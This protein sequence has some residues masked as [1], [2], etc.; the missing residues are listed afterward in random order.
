MPNGRGPTMYIVTPPELPR[1]LRLADEI[2]ALGWEVEIADTPERGAEAG[3]RGVCIIMLTRDGW[4]DPALVE[5]I[6]QRPTILVPVLAEPMPLPNG[7]WTSDPI[8]M[9]YSLQEVAAMVINAIDM[10]TSRSSATR[11]P[12]RPRDGM[13]ESRSPSRLRDDDGLQR[14]S[15]ESRVPS[16]PRPPADDR[17]YARSQPP[18]LLDDRPISRPRDD[19]RPPSRPRDYETRMPSRPRDPQE[20]FASSRPREL[21]EESFGSSRVREPA[22]AFSMSR[23][24]GMDDSFAS[25]RPREAGMYSSR[26][27]AVVGATARPR[28]TSPLPRILGIVALIAVL[29]IG[30]FGVTY[31]Q[32]HPDFLHRLFGGGGSTSAPAYTAAIPGADCD[33]GGGKWTQ[34]TSANFAFACQ[35]NALQITQSGGFDTFSGAFF[36]G[37]G[38]AIAQ[39]YR[40]QV[41]ASIS[42]TETT[43]TAGIL[44]HLASLGG[45]QIASGQLFTINARGAWAVTRIA[46]TGNVQLAIGFLSQPAKSYMLTLDVSGAV[47]T[48]GINGVAVG[49]V[50]D[51]TYTGTTGIGL[52]VANPLGKQAAVVSY[53]QFSFT[54]LG[55]P[56]LSIDQA[57]AT[58]TAQA[59]QAIQTAYVA[60]LPGPGCDKGSAQWA[61]PLALGLDGT[62]TCDATTMTLAK[63]TKTGDSTYVGYFGQ[64]GLL[65]A[66]L[67]VEVTVNTSKLGGGCAT[68]VT[69]KTDKGSY[70]FAICQDGSWDINVFLNGVKTKLR[71]GFVPVATT[72]ALAVTDNG[73]TKS[74]TLNGLSA[75]TTNTVLTDTGVVELGVITAPGGTGSAA[76]SNFKVTPITAGS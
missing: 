52:I 8:E 34:T 7:P 29:F 63:D 71:G 25:S 50:T 10:P 47:L 54:P 64:L 23:P 37:T 40:I 61:P 14:P 59:T 39:N 75:T 26:R 35:N 18:G 33:K 28:N 44:V 41:T 30:G 62:V 70:I 27:S 38:T 68:I 4:R 20:A 31:I 72:Y 16:R 43:D 13:S 67:K 2:Y 53:D 65:P 1:A 74:F 11:A 73:G 21:L 24:R 42:G 22:D 69:R 56:A 12:S 49:S 3:Q 48:L 15:Y 57:A 66:N 45:D 9:R 32:K 5:A 55:S 60:A 19:D 36:A 76:F 17:G 46:S 58:A 6:R 51:T